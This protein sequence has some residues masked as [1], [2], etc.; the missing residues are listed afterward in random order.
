MK[1][2]IYW[3]LFF[4]GLMADHFWGDAGKYLEVVYYGRAFYVPLRLKIYHGV[5]VWLA[6]LGSANRVARYWYGFPG[7]RCSLR[8]SVK[9]VGTEVWRKLVECFNFIFIIGKSQL[10]YPNR[11]ELISKYVF[12]GQNLQQF[13]STQ[14]NN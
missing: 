2:I 3:V 10:I 4:L 14:K 7:F 13:K 8:D 6:T 9:V 5:V 12:F 1:N 11:D